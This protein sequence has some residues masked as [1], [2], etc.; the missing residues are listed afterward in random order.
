MIFPRAGPIDHRVPIKGRRQ[1]G[2]GTKERE[3]EKKVNDSKLALTLVVDEP[4]QG[5]YQYSNGKALVSSW[6]MH[7][8]GHYY[9]TYYI[10]P[11]APYVS[12]S[13]Q[14]YYSITPLS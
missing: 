8:I 14:Y 7:I 13:L 10:S 12:I 11:V 5:V 9:Y 3:E 2:V 6:H 4:N 1:G